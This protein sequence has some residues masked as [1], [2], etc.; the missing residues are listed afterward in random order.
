MVVRQFRLLLLTRELMDAGGS[1]D[2]VIRE[3]HLYPYVAGKLLGQAKRFDLNGLEII[4]HH[5]LDLDEDIKTGQMTID[6]ALELLVVELA[7]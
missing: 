2:V 5:L 6:L 7:L 4:Y 1:Q 3:L